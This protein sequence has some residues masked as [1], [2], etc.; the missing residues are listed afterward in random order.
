M[1]LSHIA[2]ASRFLVILLLIGWAAGCQKSKEKSRN[3][4]DDLPTLQVRGVPSSVEAEVYPVEGAIDRRPV[5]VVISE[6]AGDCG[7]IREAYLGQV[8]VLCHLPGGAEADARHFESRVRRAL[9]YLKSTY[10]TYVAGAPLHLFSSSRYSS[11]ALRMVLREP[12]VFAYSY[13]EGV[14]SAALSASVFVALADQ[15]ARILLVGE[16]F[17]PRTASLAAAARRRGL[18]SA[19]V[20]MDRLGLDRAAR[21]FR[22]ADPRIA[23]THNSAFLTK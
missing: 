11:G 15:G 2:P 23:P 7:A 18:W 22:R 20:G 1:K 4:Q 13:L 8:H 16:K 6:R 19:G 9:S 12:A 3:V 5:A 17:A 14:R 21:T 10:P